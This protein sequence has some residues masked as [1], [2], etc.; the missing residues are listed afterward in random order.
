L[1]A[2]VC[3][4]HNPAAGGCGDPRRSPCRRESTA[5]FS[6]G[7]AAG[8]EGK[9]GRRNPGGMEEQQRMN[10]VLH[11]LENFSEKAFVKNHQ[12]TVVISDN[13]TIHHCICC[14]GCWIKTPG[15]CVIDDAYSHMGALLSQCT[16]FVIISRC[17]YG[18]YS[19]FVHNVLDRSIP[20]I[21]PYFQTQNDETHHQR[22]YDNHI[23][24]IVHFYGKISE[25]ERETARKLVT[26]NSGNLF[27]CKKTEI[28]F[29]SAA[30]EVQDIL[31]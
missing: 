10:I 28:H 23:D 26:A 2:R 5:V 4:G 3:A 24:L 31:S 29:Y 6:L 17:F 20:Y 16:R 13:G 18:S 11:D 8:G 25:Q 14:Y 9:Y 27:S 30:D 1:T 12:D 21:L 7:A 15:R 19:P 22:R